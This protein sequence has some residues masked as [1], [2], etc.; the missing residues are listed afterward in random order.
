MTR[1]VLRA[2]GHQVDSV[3]RTSSRGSRAC[4]LPQS[5][6]GGLFSW[7]PWPGACH[8]LSL[9]RVN[10]RGRN[11]QAPFQGLFSPCVGPAEGPQLRAGSGPSSVR[12]APYS[13]TD[14]AQAQKS[15]A[16]SQAAV[17][18]VQAAAQG[19]VSVRPGGIPLPPAFLA[20]VWGCTLRARAL[21]PV[22]TVALS[23]DSGQHCHRPQPWPLGHVGSSTPPGTSVH[24]GQ[25]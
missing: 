9:P 25:F 20:P 2:R 1:T 22:C 18:G 7:C 23:W 10:G 13:R 16:F 17:P 5:C 4:C 11:T 15:P 8:A 6:P 3:P 19:W 14:R 24:I 12:R 21:Q